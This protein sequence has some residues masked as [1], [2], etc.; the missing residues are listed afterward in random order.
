MTS[1]PMLSMINLFFRGTREEA[2]LDPLLHLV[3]TPHFVHSSQVY[4]S[5]SVAYWVWNEHLQVVQLSDNYRRFRSM[6]NVVADTHFPV[7]QKFAPVNEFDRL[8][9]EN[10]FEFLRYKSKEEELEI[11][12]QLGAKVLVAGLSRDR[13]LLSFFISASALMARDTT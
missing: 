2:S 1:R 3:R 6:P 12:R 13:P 11:V 7:F 5:S 4:I 8:D 9:S 10:L